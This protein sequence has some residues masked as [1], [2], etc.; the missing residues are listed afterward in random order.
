MPLDALQKISNTAPKKGEMWRHWKGHVC[1]IESVAHP[2]ETGE[3]L[4]VYREE[5]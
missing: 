2:T 3:L 1:E 4:V 5:G